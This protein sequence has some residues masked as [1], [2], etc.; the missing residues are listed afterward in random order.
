[1]S[2]VPGD[3][4]SQKSSAL[5]AGNVNFNTF[6]NPKSLFLDI[7]QMEHHARVRRNAPLPGSAMKIHSSSLLQGFPAGSSTLSSPSQ[8][9]SATIA[10]SSATSSIFSTKLD[11]FTSSKHSVDLAATSSAVLSPLTTSSPSSVV[12]EESHTAKASPSM[13]LQS[14]S[15]PSTTKGTSTWLSLTV[16]VADTT[17]PTSTVVA[18]FPGMTSSNTAFSSSSSTTSGSMVGES[19]EMV[20]SPISS[21]QMKSSAVIVTSSA[22][23]APPFSQSG[24]K[25]TMGT[26]SNVQTVVTSPSSVISSPVISG[27][28]GFDRSSWVV[29]TTMPPSSSGAVVTTSST[30]VEPSLSSSVA[31]TSSM[32]ALT[33]YPSPESSLAENSVAA[34]AQVNSSTSHVIITGSPSTIA[35]DVSS[36]PTKLALTSSFG[37]RASSFVAA[38]NVSPTSLAVGSFSPYESEFASKSTRTVQDSTMSPYS[39]RRFTRSFSTVSREKTSVVS[40]SQATSPSPLT[41]SSFVSSKPITLSVQSTFMSSYSSYQTILSL[42]SVANQEVTTSSFSQT[43]SFSSFVTGNFS[44]S[45]PSSQESSSTGMT[46]ASGILTSAPVSSY[47][48]VMLPSSTQVQPTSSQVAS[49]EPPPVYKNETMTVKFDGDCE[50]IVGD[51]I[52]KEEF[53]AAFEEEVSIKLNIEKSFIRVNSITCGSILVTFTATTATGGNTTV[54]ESLALVI[55]SGNITVTALGKDFKA[56][57]V[58]VVQPTTAE[59]PVTTTKTPTKNKTKLILYITLSVVIGVILIAGIVGLIVRYRNDQQSGGFFLTNES[60]NYELRR[61]H[62]LPR[63]KNYSKVNYYGEPVELDATA[64]DPN[65]PDEFQAQQSDFQYN[66]G[67]SLDRVKPIAASN[68]DDKFNVGTMGLP[69]WKNLPRLSKAEVAVTDDSKNETSMS[70]DEGKTQLLRDESTSLANPIVT[71]GDVASGLEK[72]EGLVHAYDNPAVAEEDGPPA[73]E[74]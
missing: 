71:F 38:G 64:T 9:I 54:A 31:I 20:T 70:M 52:A 3:L 41:S 36:I 40:S 8:S 17:S 42:A 35:L 59:I 56:V 6:N 10:Y 21:S 28:T 49:S 14:T 43:S 69:E 7:L 73:P 63:S 27:S 24:S 67:S 57:N 30:T 39:T 11:T 55:K 22:V 48:T 72:K 51:K 68:N 16:S 58:Q 15:A 13:Y 53:K 45:Q 37:F 2:A 65:T 18:L 25:V 4:T 74:K 1:M 44:S 47:T 60:T 23:L 46:I 26:S 66:Q 50:V 33:A 32:L 19:S 61:F 12:R 62:G 34:S 5:D 29:T